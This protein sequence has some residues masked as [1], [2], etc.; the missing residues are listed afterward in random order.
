MRYTQRI[1][2]LLPLL[3][4]A[5]LAPPGCSS[6]EDKLPRRPIA[7]TVT[8][9]GK[10]LKAGTIQFYPSSVKEG[11]AAGGFVVDGQFRVAQKEG[12]VPGKYSVMIFARDENAAPP[13]PE[14]DMPGVIQARKST[15]GLIPV[16]YNLETE[17]TAE[18][19]ADGPNTYEFVLKKK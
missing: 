2:G 19:K 18:V 6:D 8:F 13:P 1:V 9:D 5:G 7:G 16:R 12:P 15:A 4:A 11:I 14:G 17:L 10:P 3:V